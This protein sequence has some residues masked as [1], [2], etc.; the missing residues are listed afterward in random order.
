MSGGLGVGDGGTIGVGVQVGVAVGIGV[1]VVGCA[2]GDGRVGSGVAVADAV[3]DS[4]GDCDGDVDEGVR[5]GVNVGVR[6]SKTS[7]AA[8]FLS[9]ANC[10]T[11]TRVTMTSRCSTTRVNRW[12]S[13]SSNI[14]KTSITLKMVSNR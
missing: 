12:R 6:L 4:D 3:G 11:T 10:I 2:V 14:M 8:L 13:E 1:S 9:Q 7:S 5:K